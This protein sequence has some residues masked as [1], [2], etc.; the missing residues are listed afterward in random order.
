MS[1]YIDPAIGKQIISELLNGHSIRKTA[2]SCGCAKNTVLRYKQILDA[3]EFAFGEM[4]DRKKICPCG[5]SIGHKGWCRFRFNTSVKRQE[6]IK[7]WKGN[8]NG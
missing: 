7:Q 8:R 1:N 6:F 2:H 5:K 3:I 4:D